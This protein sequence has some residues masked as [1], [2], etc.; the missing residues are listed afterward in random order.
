MAGT[1]RV[2]VGSRIVLAIAAAGRRTGG[3]GVAGAGFELGAGERGE[4]DF[5]GL[6]DSDSAEVAFR[7]V[8]DHI[9]VAVPGEPVHS[10]SRGNDLTRIVVF[11][12]RRRHAIFDCDWSSDVCS[13]D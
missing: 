11:A 13:S 9:G 1:G 7:G 10:L 5:R 6:A 4:I 12:S 2:N 8:Q 3:G